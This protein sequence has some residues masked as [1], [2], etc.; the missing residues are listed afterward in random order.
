MVEAKGLGERRHNSPLRS[1]WG[2]WVFGDE[3]ELD[4]D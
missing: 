2:P 3:V 4:D 1:D